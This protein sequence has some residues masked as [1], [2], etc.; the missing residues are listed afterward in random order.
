MID[1][2]VA[3]EKM[4]LKARPIALQFFRSK[5]LAVDKKADLSLVTQADRIL[6]GMFIDELGRLTPGWPVIGEEGNGAGISLDEALA[7][8]RA[9]WVLDPLDGT[10]EFVDGTDEWAM[11]LALYQPARGVTQAFIY[12]PT[13]NLYAWAIVGDGAYCKNISTGAVA[14]LKSSARATSLES[15]L[16]VS[17]SRE[18]ARV[19]ALCELHEFGAKKALGSIGLKALDIAAG[20]SDLY[21]N[22]DARCGPWDLLPCLPFLSESGAEWIASRDID[23]GAELANKSIDLVFAFGNKNLLRTLQLNLGAEL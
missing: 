8:D 23:W 4:F 16:L 10:R 22:G 3:V 2:A 15:T 13:S 7:K 1:L 19:S 12:Q 20:N 5:D 11:M 9:I 21:L 17:K 14:R 6:N 18:D